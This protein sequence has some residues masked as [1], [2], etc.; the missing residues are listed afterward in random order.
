ML[1]LP[2]TT[3]TNALEIMEEYGK[4][5]RFP[6]LFSSLTRRI[7]GIGA[8]NTKMAAIGAA[9]PQRSNNIA[10]EILMSTALTIFKVD[11]SILFFVTR[12]R[13]MMS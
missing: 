5:G 6:T 12:I 8:I 1:F 7:V 9:F 2:Y 10:L 13:L 4:R 11:L 3:Q